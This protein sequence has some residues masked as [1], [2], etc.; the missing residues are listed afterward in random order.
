MGGGGG[1][2]GEGG[3]GGDSGGSSVKSMAVAMSYSTT[4]FTPVLA[5][6]QKGPLFPWHA[7]SVITFVFKGCG[8]LAERKYM[9]PSTPASYTTPV[10]VLF[11]AQCPSTHM[12]T[13]VMPVIQSGEGAIM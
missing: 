10:T 8:K 2:E 5:W 3:G 1:G 7:T 6:L 11:L 13:A 12:S 4:G 9:P